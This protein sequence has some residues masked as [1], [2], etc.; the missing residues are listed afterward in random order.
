LLNL[1]GVPAAKIAQIM[2]QP[3][4]GIRLVVGGGGGW[5][6]PLVRDPAKVLT[7][8]EDG[9]YSVSFAEQAHG[10]VIR[11]GVVDENDTGK[12]RAELA[13]AREDGTWTVPTACPANWTGQPRIT[14]EVSA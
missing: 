5:G 9:V 6:D 3:G 14:V 8:V 4:Q 13:Q 2:L 12:R 10:V 7:D 11:D 1:A